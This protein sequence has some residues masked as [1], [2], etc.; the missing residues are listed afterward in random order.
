ME[1]LKAYKFRIYP[2]KIQ[3][4]ELAVQFGHSRFVYNRFIDNRKTTFLTTGK[5]VS[6]YDFKKQ[7]TAMKQQPEF[8]WL[9]DADSQVLQASL[10]DAD[11]AYQ[12]F[13]RNHKAGTLPPVGK[14]PRKDGMPK[15]YPTFW[16]KHDDQ[17][18]RYPQRFKLA[19][20][21]IYLPKVG[22]VKGVF[23]RDIE[24]LTKNATVSKTKSGRYFVSIQC[25]VEIDVP[26]QNPNAVGVDVGLKSFATLSTGEKID[27]PKF[28]R[29]SERLLKIRQRRLS[30]KVKGSSNR[31]KARH[32][33]AVQHE[34]VANQ[35]KD[36]HHQISRQLVN[37]FGLIAV[38]DL[39]IRGMMRNPHLAKSIADV[40]W[41]QFLNFVEYKQKWNGGKLIRND[42]WFASSK[43]CS[44]CGAVNHSL[45]LS[46][47]EWV[48]VSCGAIHD[49]D[50]NAAINHL[51]KAT[52]GAPESLR[53]G[54]TSQPVRNSAQ[55][56][57]AF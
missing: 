41:S 53:L 38:E 21:R 16:S 29:R 56:A 48:C 34:R 25:E 54:D 45:K 42:R 6:F 33:V 22:W 26:E 7:V 28:L 1:I 47:R 55:E 30:H 31:N 17:S 24:G 14:K 57:H 51:N 18:I 32:R 4:S 49:R 2:N 23:H 13:F 20:K 44:D 3:Q 5:S 8:A 10:E 37:S 46:D 19:G 15:G 11:R 43:T 39:N 40:G 27:A 52:G 9:K 36:F 50:E 12:N 35:L